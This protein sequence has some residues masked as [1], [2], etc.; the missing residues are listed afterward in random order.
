MATESRGGGGAE[1]EDRNI[2][3]ILYCRTALNTSFENELSV[4]QSALGSRC[5]AGKVAAVKVTGVFCDLAVE[6]AM[7]IFTAA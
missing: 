4:G 2:N 6:M 1:R 3:R 7:V 5:H